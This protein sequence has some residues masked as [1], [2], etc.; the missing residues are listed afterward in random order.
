MRPKLPKVPTRNKKSN[1]SS[2]KWPTGEL[3]SIAMTLNEPERTE[4]LEEYER[5]KK[6][7]EK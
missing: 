2:L 4:M 7:E 3:K 1:M 6:R 5:R